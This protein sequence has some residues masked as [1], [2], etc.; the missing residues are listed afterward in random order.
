MDSL[1]HIIFIIPQILLPCQNQT[2]TLTEMLVAV[3]HYG[4]GCRCDMPV[5]ANV[6]VEL[7]NA[8][9]ATNVW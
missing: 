4:Q 6:Y 5:A 1:K 9:Q 3:M 2:P 7:I 8:R